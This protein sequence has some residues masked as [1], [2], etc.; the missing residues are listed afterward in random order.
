MF[1]LYQNTQSLDHFA[2]CKQEAI[3][4]CIYDKENLVA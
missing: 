2:W 1:K 4:L 3:K